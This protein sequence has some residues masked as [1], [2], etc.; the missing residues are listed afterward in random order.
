V[1]AVAIPERVRE[2]WA[3]EIE[4][5]RRAVE[6]AEAKAARDAERTAEVPALL[7]SAT[8]N[9]TALRAKVE[10]LAPELLSAL[11]ACAAARTEY[12]SAFGLALKYDLVNEVRIAPLAIGDAVTAVMSLGGR[13]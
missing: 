10:A 6:V 5:D 4:A 8:E 13:L 9:Y 7:A 2:E 12:E 1:S 11:E 3:A